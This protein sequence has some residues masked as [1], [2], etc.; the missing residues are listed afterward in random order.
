MADKKQDVL[1]K[2]SNDIVKLREAGKL[3]ARIR[4]ELV[5]EVEAGITTKYLDDK[6]SQLIKGYGAK[7]VFL[8]YR[9]Y[10][11]TVCV[12]VNSEVVH[13]IPSEKK[14]LKE[15]DI[16]S[17]DIGILYN[18]YCGDTATT[19][20]IGKI[21]SQANKLMDAGRISLE[22][23]IEKT[24]SGNRIGD[25]SW[26]IQKHVEENGF[27]VVRDFTGHGIGKKMHEDPQIPNFGMP[28][29]GLKLVPGMVLAL[30]T[31]VNAGSWAIKILSDDWTV[32]TVDGSLSVHFEHMVLVSETGPAILT[33]SS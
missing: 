9:G 13:G 32:V 14:V 7:P 30:E 5:K 18:G 28:G 21:S 31:M 3:V 17:L 8:G 11:A 6:A 4:E 26:A 29:K 20:G 25:I 16:V 15:G 10:P 2:N 19:L 22:K 24:V 23:A 27:S 33:N 1:V 12:S